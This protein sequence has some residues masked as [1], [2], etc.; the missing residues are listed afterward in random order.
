MMKLFS[1]N[2]KDKSIEGEVLDELGLTQCCRRH[3]LIMLIFF[4]YDKYIQ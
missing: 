4:K 1:E 2:Y 3:M